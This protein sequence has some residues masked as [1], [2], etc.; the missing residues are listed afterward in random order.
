MKI[1]IKFCM[2]LGLASRLI[3]HCSVHHDMCSYDCVEAASKL[4]S[5]DNQDM[6]SKSEGAWKKYQ[7]IF[8]ARKQQ[9]IN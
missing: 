6:C 5:Q 9:L 2:Y 4:T 8:K 1:E 7:G 3:L